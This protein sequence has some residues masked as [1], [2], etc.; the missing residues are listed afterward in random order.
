MW[1]P[2][3]APPVPVNVSVGTVM[4]ALAVAV[5]P[6]APRLITSLPSAPKMLCAVTRVPPRLANVMVSLAVDAV[7][8]C[9]A[10]GMP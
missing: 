3:M 7:S 4:A 9:P 6:R 1:V 2:E 5:M 8:A 10:E